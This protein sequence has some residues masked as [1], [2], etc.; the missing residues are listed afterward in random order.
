MCVRAC[1]CVCALLCRGLYSTEN[2]QR[3]QVEVTQFQTRDLKR[4]GGEEE[5]GGGGV[6]NREEEEETPLVFGSSTNNT[7]A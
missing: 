7:E 5:R 2:P 3:T 4:G 6:G 1:A